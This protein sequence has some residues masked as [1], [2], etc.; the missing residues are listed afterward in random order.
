MFEQS[1]EV[2]FSQGVEFGIIGQYSLDMPQK[3]IKVIAKARYGSKYINGALFPDREFTQYRAFVLRNSGNDCVW[4]RMVDGVQSRLIDQLDTTVIHQAWRPVI[5]YINGQYWGHYNLRERVS[6]YFVAQH[7]GLDMSKA[8]TIDV[9]ESNGTKSSQVNN[10]SNAEWK[11]FISTVKTLSP[12]TNAADLQ[13]ILDRVDVD[14][15]FDYVIFESFFANTDTGNIRFYKVPG[16]KWRWL[17]YDMDY[18]LFNY[19]SNGIGNYLNPKG[20]GANNDIDNSL[21]LKLLE[22]SEMKDKFLTRFGEVFRFFTT[23]R[24]LAQIDECYRILEPEMEMHF[25]RWAA[26]NLKNISFDQ[27]KTK[28]GCI[29]WWNQRVTRLRN[30]VRKRPAYCWRQVAEW[31]GMTDAQMTYY[32]GPIPIISEEATWDTEKQKENAMTYLYGPNWKTLY[33]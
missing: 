14:N 9:L 20:H 28:D 29:R 7:E 26:E 8:K 2:V 15:Y 22:N 24:M 12:G 4:T 27:P 32:F 18:G 5:V 10:G 1:G 11:E 19:G 23:E 16:R 6:E 3:S 30:I 13:Y 17:L 25:D 33:Q 31:F 21:I